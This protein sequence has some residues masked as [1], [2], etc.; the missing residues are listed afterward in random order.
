MSEPKRPAPSSGS[1]PFDWSRLSNEEFS[2]REAEMREDIR[3]R[4]NFQ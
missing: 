3:Q 1:T 2:K 4:E